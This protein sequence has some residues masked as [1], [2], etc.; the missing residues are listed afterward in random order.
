MSA[1]IDTLTDKLKNSEYWLLAIASGLI[2]I[3]LTLT[4]Q[5]NQSSLLGASFVFWAGIS[6]LIWDKRHRL[7]LKSGAFASFCGLLIIILA[8]LKSTFPIHLGGVSHLLPSIFALGLALLASGFQGL[9]QYTGELLALF[10]LAAPKLIPPSLIDISLLT[11]KF[12]T[13]VLWYTGFNV[14]REGV[15][16]NLSTGS[17]IV[18]FPCSGMEEILH[19]LGLAI[20]CLIIFPMTIIQKILVPIVAIIIAFIVNGLRVVLMAILTAQ[21]QKESFEYWHMG[22]G[23]L[24]FSLIAVVIFGCL[25]SFLPFKKEVKN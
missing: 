10:F 2:T 9:K 3:H 7:S 8:L 12:S 18:N 14:I 25:F 6:F 13:V 17:V 21:G 16:I 1:N 20:L 24:I 11:A 22:D 15:N 5:A 4:W 23:S 19:L